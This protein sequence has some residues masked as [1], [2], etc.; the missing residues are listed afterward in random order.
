[1]AAELRI[2]RLQDEQEALD[3]SRILSWAFALDAHE[4]ARLIGH[5]GPDNVRIA[6]GPAGVAAGLLL[7]PMGQWF[8][9]RSVP[10]TGIAAVATAPEQRGRGVAA[11]LLTDVL[12]ELA[13]RKTALSTLYPAALSL[14][15]SVGYEPAGSRYCLRVRLADIG[16][17]DRDLSISPIRDEDVPAVEAA[18]RRCAVAS[19]GYLDRSAYSWRRV[20]C[21]RGQEARGFMV[22]VGGDVEAY[23][24]AVEEGRDARSRY[25][26]VLTDVATVN[27]RAGRNLLGFLSDHRSMASEAVW[28]GG[29][30]SVLTSLLPEPTYQASLVDHFAVRVVDVEQALVARGYPPVDAELSIEVADPLLEQN[31]GPFRL[32]V[33]RGV[34]VVRRVEQAQL[35]V[36]IRG[37]A[38]LYTGFLSPHALQTAGLLEGSE[39]AVRVAG[40]LF[41][42]PAP[43]MPDTF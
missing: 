38:P 33:S 24:Y 20:R 16:V 39:R 36:D 13:S 43:V 18:Y 8:G 10:M 30:A 4:P 3:F 5:A 21:P 11:K 41:S 1:M 6:V 2:R 22:C 26:L 25:R 15:R 7:L 27:E 34:G 35:R 37:L 40:A 19:A 17:R 14:Y 9:G 32:Q 31:R 12:R 23:L 29:A 28:H 42:G